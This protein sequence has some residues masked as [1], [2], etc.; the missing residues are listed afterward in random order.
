[1]YYC[2]AMNYIQQRKGSDK[3]QPDT[4]GKYLKTNAAGQKM[5]YCR[6][7]THIQHNKKVR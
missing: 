6:A 3:S 2:R 7:M 5:F 4:I 1:M